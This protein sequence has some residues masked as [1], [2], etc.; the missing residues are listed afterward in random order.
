M[1]P[2]VCRI[3]GEEKEGQPFNSWVKDTFTNYDRLFPGEII[4]EDCLF[5]FDQHSEKL[6]T[7]MGK[8]KPQ[9]MQNYSHF[10]VSGEWIPISKGDKARM[11]E[12]LLAES[13]PELVAIAVSGQKHLAFRARRNQ[14]GQHGGW[15]QFEEQTVWV[16]QS[17]LKGLLEV[18]EDLYTVFSKGEIESGNYFPVRVIEFG[19]DRWQ[20]LEN[21]L[22]PVRK[23][24]LFQLALFL[25]QR[26]EDDGE[27]S[28]TSGGSNDALDHLA[29]DTVRL[30]E[31]I[32][33]DDL[34]TVRERNQVG[35]VHEQ[36]AEIHQLD[37]FSFGR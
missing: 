3:C 37:L 8:E 21:L 26:S 27:E 20:E 32:P 24:A 34:G 9:K 11:A 15:V 13:F 28:E 14:P 23:T 33:D 36:P 7:L 29:G 16:D 10:I 12:L 19:I 25:A 17:S 22:K 6:Q 1:T 35:G 30:Q 18:I 2:G 5:W 31:Q 4:C